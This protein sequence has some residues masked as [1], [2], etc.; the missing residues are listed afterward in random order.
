MREKLQKEQEF[1]QHEM[2]AQQ[3]Q[4]Q[5]GV[6]HVQIDKA[7]PIQVV[8]SSEQ[9]TSGE[10]GETFQGQDISHEIEW[11]LKHLD[12]DMEQQELEHD[13]DLMHHQREVESPASMHL[14][15][16]KVSGDQGGTEILGGQPEVEMHK[17][18][19]DESHHRVL[20]SQRVP[21][22]EDQSSHA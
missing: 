18:S 7:T 4:I 17:L 11:A 6:H 2:E 10:Q 14:D 21:T 12:A 15:D 3:Q 22:L 19:F 9:L 16:E 8:D 20:K 1:C 5:Q 13:V